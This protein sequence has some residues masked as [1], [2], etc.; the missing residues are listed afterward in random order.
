[1]QRFR[2][3]QP[4][5]SLW[6]EDSRTGRPF[7]DLEPPELAIALTARLPLDPD[8]ATQTPSD[9]AIQRWQL[10]P[11]AEA[12]VPGPTPH[13]RVQVGDH[14]L[15]AD[16]PMP[17][18]QFA[19][20]VFEPGHGLVGN[21]PP[22]CRIILDREAEERPVPRSGDGTLLGV[23]LQLEAPFD[24]A[25]QAR[26]DPPA[27][28]FAA[29]VDVT[30]IRVPHEPVAATLKLAIQF[31]Q[32]EVQ[33]Q[34]RERTALRGPFPA[35]LEQPAI[36]HTSRQVSP[37][38]PENPPVRDPRRYPCHQPVVIDPVKELCQVDIHDKPVAFDDVGL[39]L[40]HR[41]MGGAAR[42]EAVAVLA[43]CRVPLRLKPLQ[44]RL[45]D[46]AIDHGWDAEVARPAGRLRDLYPT[47][48]LRLVAPLE[49]LIFDLRPARF[50]DARQLFDGDPVDAGRP[51]VAHHCT[52]RCLYVVR[53]TDRLH[54]MRCGCRAF[55]FG[56]RRDRFDLLHVP[57]RGFTPVR[58]RQA[59]FE[60]VWRSRFGHETP[61][62]FA[63]SFNPLSG[64]VRAFGRRT[65]LLCPLLTSAP[66]SGRLATAS[67]PKDTAQIS[68]SKPDSLHRTPAGFT[69]LALDGYG[70]CDILPARPTSG[71]SYPVSVRRVA[72]LLHASF[73]RSLAVPP[74]RF[75]SASPPSGCTG[76][77]HPQNCR[78]CP[79][80]RTLCAGS[81]DVAA[82]A[83]ASLTAAARG[84][85]P[86]G[87]SGRRDGGFR[88][89]KGMG[90]EAHAPAAS[91]TS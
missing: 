28:L 43:E 45:L 85:L 82:F 67:V 87:R 63:L 74:L 66:R 29:D 25:G 76:D 40:R 6:A 78:T 79:T 88:S 22:E 2:E 53:V 55:G 86:G 13:K 41:L 27:G 3:A 5:R 44:D 18:R 68:R 58:H 56:R 8:D 71:A 91:R 89:N 38:H 64:T 39:R 54:E 49:Q 69:V 7:G 50:E 46:H 81:A 14:L 15:Q 33:E 42:P 35:P 36:E 59:Q 19:N 10:A 83:A 65:G 20:P 16:A 73:R 31:I 90:G 1:M 77:F 84:A 26:H 80:H 57:A 4:P 52:Q 23:D 51:L 34:G 72:T 48:R 12:E 60:L 47:H 9:P 75:A 24:E 21:A 62:L 37:D 61:D 17:P 70:L 30:V 32:D 11:L